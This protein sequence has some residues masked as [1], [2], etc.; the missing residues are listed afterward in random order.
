MTEPLAED[1]TVSPEDEFILVQSPIDNEP[2]QVRVFDMINPHAPRANKPLRQARM[3]ICR[4]CPSLHGMH[5]CAEC[6]C[7]M[8]AKTWLKDATCP[9]K[10]WN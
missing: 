8:P 2:R 5:M 1:F 6:G 3:A 4:E 9:L 10:K 7:F